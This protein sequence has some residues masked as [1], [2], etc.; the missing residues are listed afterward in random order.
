MVFFIV[1]V[2]HAGGGRSNLA[3]VEK[4]PVPLFFSLLVGRRRVGLGR[5]WIDEFVGI[6]KLERWPLRF[7]LKF[8]IISPAGEVAKESC[9]S[10]HR[11]KIM[12]LIYLYIF[13][14][15]KKFLTNKSFSSLALG[16]FFF[17]ENTFWRERERERRGKK[18]KERKIGERKSSIIERLFYQ[19]MW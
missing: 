14:F 3:V 10:L 16:N 19:Y 6:W 12:F 4:V 1:V 18:K 17:L 7:T 15:K 2:H 9:L 11:K 8:G 13:F 5:V